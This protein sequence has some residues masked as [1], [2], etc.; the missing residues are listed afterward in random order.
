MR[1]RLFGKKK[2]S[3]EVELLMEYLPIYEIWFS[4]AGN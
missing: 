1:N 2:S 3:E 4:L